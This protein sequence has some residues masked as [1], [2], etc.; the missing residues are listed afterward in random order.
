MTLLPK[1]RK[2]T[3]I[4]REDEPAILNFEQIKNLAAQW[5]GRLMPPRPPSG[6]PNTAPSPPAELTQSNSTYAMSGPWFSSEQPI[7]ATNRGTCTSLQAALVQG[8]DQDTNNAVRDR[9]ALPPHL[10]QPLPQYRIDLALPVAVRQT[11]PGREFDHAR[12]QGAALLGDFN[13]RHRSRMDVVEGS[14]GRAFAQ[15][16][17]F[18]QLNRSNPFS[19]KLTSR[20]KKGGPK[21]KFFPPPVV[22][23]KHA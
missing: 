7:I 19:K 4:V 22:E 10:L 3:I 15:P 1:E 18:G 14:Q 11:P 6:G 16:G 13:F 17:T 20:L 23:R 9:L 2:Q 8:D 5:D 21:S 12:D